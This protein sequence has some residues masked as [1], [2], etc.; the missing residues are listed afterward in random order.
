MT[1]GLAA[2]QAAQAALD[3]VNGP[4]EQLREQHGHDRGDDERAEDGADRRAQGALELA[5]HEQ[6]GDAD[7]DGSETARSPSSSGSRT[8]TSR[9]GSVKITHSWLERAE[10]EQLV[11]LLAAAAACDRCGSGS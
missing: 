2:L 7:P 9:P 11:H 6:G 10:L 1:P 8:S 4:E 3:D 5:A